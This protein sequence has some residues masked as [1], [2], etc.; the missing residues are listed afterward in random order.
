MF[1]FFCQINP[2][3]LQGRSE[4]SGSYTV[5]VDFSVLTFLRRSYYFIVPKF[6]GG[7]SIT[8]LSCLVTE[9]H[10]GFIYVVI[11]IWSGGRKQEKT[12]KFAGNETSRRMGP[13]CTHTANAKHARIVWVD[14]KQWCRRRHDDLTFK[15][16]VLLSQTIHSCFAIAFRTQASTRIGI[17]FRTKSLSYVTM[18]ITVFIA[19]AR[20]MI[21]W[22]H[23]MA[24]KKNWKVFLSSKHESN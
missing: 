23:A 4:L 19:P 1:Q 12:L 21:W 14:K 13:K 22:L 9:I 10:G 5:F 24:E 18:M 6:V 20:E 11:L 3:S 2:L 17:E 7:R 16:A 15:I 8:T